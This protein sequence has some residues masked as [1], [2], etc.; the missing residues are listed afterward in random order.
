MKDE[1]ILQINNLTKTYKKYTL[2]DNVS[3]NVRKNTVY[4]LLGP[5]GAGK[6]TT[7]KIIA[8][9]LKKT[10]GEIMFNGKPWS[11]DNLMDIG[12]L[13]ENA[14][15]YGNLTAKENLEVI[16]RSNFLGYR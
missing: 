16:S 6:S 11:R 4:G 3:I 7:L 15:L 10:S 12:S 8:G 1:F 14:P 9:L 5:N 13:I 2:L